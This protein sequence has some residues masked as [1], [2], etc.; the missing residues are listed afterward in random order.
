MKKNRKIL[1]IIGIFLI[2]ITSLIL[3]FNVFSN[4]K[5]EDLT[6]ESKNI[7]VYNI[8]DEKEVLNINGE[9][10]VAPA[11]LTK[12]MTVI[13]SIENI[14]DISK[15]APVDKKTYQEMVAV[16]A[17]MTGFYGNEQTTYRDLL[18]GTMLASGGESANSLAINISKTTEEFTKL[19]NEKAKEIGLNNT[20]FTNP[21]GLDEE[22][23]Y[24]T[25][26]DI[27]ELIKNSLD[28]SEFREIF[29][30]EEYVSTSTLDHPEGIEIKST[31]LTALF[32]YEQN[33]FKIIGGK[34]GTT[35]NAGFCWA[36]LS[37]KNNR[38]YICVV[39]GAE[40]NEGRIE[41]TLKIMGEI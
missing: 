21:E 35:E 37:E 24:S 23:N 22:N 1:L 10:K 34:S 36:T 40:T 6:F 17:S 19:M 14:D 38:E 33:G 12:I 31:V 5:F 25:A 29:T 8:T 2:I 7:Y 3:N 11:S 9:E 28:N 13:T 41:D 20:N 26:K 30:K 18:Y 39:M 27:A 4:N 16:N 32:D 15:V